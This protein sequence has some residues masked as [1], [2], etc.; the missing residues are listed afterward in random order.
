[1]Y[2]DPYK[3]LS[4]NC[5]FNFIIGGRG[6]GKTYG[7]KRVAI[8]NFLKD[9]RQFV[10]VRRYSKEL[11]KAD[12]FFDDIKKEFPDNKLTVKK[13]YFYI[14]DKLAGTSMALS[15]AKIEKSTPFPEV[16]L[17]IFDEFIL[18]QGV[19]HYLAD[20]V[21]N[22]LELYSTI[23]RS[24]DVIVLFLSNALSVTNPYFIYFDLQV[25]YKSNIRAKNDILLEICD[26]KEY[27]EKMSQ[28]R[29]GKIIAG[30]DYA[31]YSVDNE[32]LRDN[33]TFIGK[34]TSKS[35]YLFT[36]YYKGK[37]YGVWIDYNGG[38]MYVSED[39]QKTCPLIYSITLED[40]QPNTLLLKGAKSSLIKLFINNY[41]LGVV[42]FESINIKNICN[43]IIKLTL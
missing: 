16:S 15:T 21:T 40:H 41:K 20:E 9:G 35:S 39:I 5:L 1:M 6:I 38:L 18:D 17:I 25:P 26:S 2:W 32:F 34:K 31:R 22:F 28:T 24:R 8:R 42:R 37:N 33:D 23:A 11:K 4:Y 7:A 36:L 3:T 27:A 12:K 43:E 30:S 14:D 29:F 10:Y 13:P 19:Y